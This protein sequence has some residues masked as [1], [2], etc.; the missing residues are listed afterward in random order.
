M[1]TY[2]YNVILST[3]VWICLLLLLT[4]S[5]T[6]R[7]QETIRV[8]YAT[9]SAA[10]MDHITAM[11][12]G[13]LREEGL[14]VEVI[15][16]PG[17]IA[18]PGLLSGQFQFSS[19]ASSAVSAAVR[20]GPVKIVYTNLSR[21]TYTLVAIKPEIVTAKD[22]VGKKIAINSF[23]DTGHLSTILYLKKMGVNPSSVLFITVGRNEVRFPALRSGAIDATPLSVRDV[24]TLKDQQHNVLA[25]LGKEIQ[26]V[27]N[28]VAVSSK[29]LADNPQ[30]VER[31]L[32]ALAKGRE[33]ARRHRD[34][35]I[36]FISKRDPSPLDA[37]KAD[38]EASKASMTED[39]S[40]PDDVLREEIATR[41]QLTKAPNPPDISEVF[42]YSITRRNYAQ[43]KAAGWQPVP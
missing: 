26:L 40:L 14:N 38:Y 19:S 27:W 32:R 33:F 22:L 31:F 15:R 23:G 25:D 16:A 35:T 4:L 9:L 7:A 37:I 21:P 34:E 8:S 43:L 36:S 3:R 28:G 6:A 17:G 39:G 2:F 20:G 1:K 29:L 42:D 13:Y 12:K 11:E 41:A 10:Y 5:T 18:T 30:L 24:V